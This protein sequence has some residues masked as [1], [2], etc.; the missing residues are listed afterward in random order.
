MRSGEKGSLDDHRIILEGLCGEIR[1][2]RRELR[3]ST[4]IKTS[5]ALQDKINHGVSRFVSKQGIDPA[6]WL[7]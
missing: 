5:G 6:L 2:L 1:N 4:S 7:T 3:Q